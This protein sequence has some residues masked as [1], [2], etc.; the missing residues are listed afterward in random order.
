MVLGSA[1]ECI[2]APGPH[3]FIQQDDYAKVPTRMQG[4]G[5]SEG[6]TITYPFSLTDEDIWPGHHRK[7]R[8]RIADTTAPF[9]RHKIAESIPLA[10][11]KV[12]FG[13]A[14]KPLRLPPLQW[15]SVVSAA[16][17]IIPCLSRP[18]DS[19]AFRYLLC[20]KLVEGCE[21]KGANSAGSG[22]QALDIINDQGQCGVKL[23]FRGGYGRG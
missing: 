7:A 2:T 15:G 8:Q 5:R 9:P 6:A 4:F 10:R 21:L 17:L 13:A 11:A 14:L 20:R 19:S 22:P 12:A 18:G 16:P 3:W 1:P 23:R